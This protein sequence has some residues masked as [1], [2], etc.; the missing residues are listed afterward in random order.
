MH[1]QTSDETTRYDLH[2]LIT[3]LIYLG[4]AVSVSG[5][6]ASV[7]VQYQSIGPQA[8]LMRADSLG[9]Y[10]QSPLAYIF[11]LSLMLAGLCM[12][13]SMYS[14][15]LLRLDRLSRYLAVCGVW[16]G[17]SVIL[18]G[19]FPINLLT[20]HRWVSSSYL[21]GTLILHG[22]TLATC[23]RPGHF[24]PRPLWLLSL[25]GFGNS[26]LLC[27]QLDWQL[28]DFPPCPQTQPHLCL[29]SIGMW[30][31]TQFTI[32]WCLTLAWAVRRLAAEQQRQ[33]RLRE[34]Q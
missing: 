28:L 4:A 9:D 14:L 12:L 7:W 32:L 27:T 23:L 6:S 29:T 22:L 16:V 5:V 21:L 25:A 26:L 1:G 15:Y 2:R 20:P 18:M 13:L 10:L 17:L 19:A 31:Q 3:A 11:N 8:L 30:L 24:C 33:A 34:T